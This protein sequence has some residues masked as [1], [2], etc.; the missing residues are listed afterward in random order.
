V[1]KS[2]ALT[3]AMWI[4]A[5]L[6]IG[7]AGIAATGNGPYGW[8]TAALFAVCAILCWVVLNKAKGK[9]SQDGD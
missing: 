5:L 2:K 3:A 4:F 7:S 8:G 6:A 1:E 9:Q